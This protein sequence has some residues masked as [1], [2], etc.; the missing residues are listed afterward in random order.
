MR[1]ECPHLP[2]RVLDVGQVG[3][4]PS[5]RLHIPGKNQRDKY[6]A[7]S[8]CW[9]GKQP[10]VTNTQNLETM[11]SEFPVSELPPALRDAVQVT[12]SLGIRFLWI[13]AL[14]VMQDSPVDKSREIARMGQIYKDATATI[15]ATAAKSA[16]E[17][18]LGG[19]VQETPNCEVYLTAPDGTSSLITIFP[20]E[21]FKFTSMPL[22]KRAWCFQEYVL[23]RRYLYYTDKNSYGSVAPLK[24]TL[25]LRGQ[26]DIHTMLSWSHLGYHVLSAAMLLTRPTNPGR[27]EGKGQVVEGQGTDQGK[28]QGNG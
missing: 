1:G 19:S 4:S 27:G 13:D 20:F 9:G 24:L 6:L 2:T 16:S 26:S 25:S 18:F 17:G 3:D 23:S 8:Y 21:E 7:L 14:C 12:R 5:V 28:N 11:K 15:I 10:F 22:S